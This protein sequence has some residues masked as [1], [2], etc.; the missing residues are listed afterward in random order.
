MEEEEIGTHL[1]ADL[2][3]ADG[4]D[5]ELPLA[6]HDLGVDAGDDEAGLDA[7]VLLIFGF[8]VG[9]FLVVCL[10]VF[11]GFFGQFSKASSLFSLPIPSPH[12]FLPPPS[13]P[14]SLSPSHH[15]RLGEGPAV[16]GRRSDAAVEGALRGGV[17][18]LRPAVDVARVGQHRVLLLEAVERGLGDDLRVAWVAWVVWVVWVEGVFGWGGGGEGGERKMGK[19]GRREEEGGGGGKR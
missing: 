9:W 12:H 7:R 4:A 15:V 17:A 5:L 1:V 19:G 6:G 14:P 18:A 8:L 2:E 10:F 3:R 11:P 13:L 16:H